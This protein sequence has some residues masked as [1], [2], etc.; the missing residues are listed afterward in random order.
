LNAE[1]VSGI[2]D[3]RSDLTTTAAAAKYSRSDGSTVVCLMYVFILDIA[4]ALVWMFWIATDNWQPAF[5]NVSSF[6][7]RDLSSKMKL[8]HRSK[9]MIV[10]QLHRWKGLATLNHGSYKGNGRKPV[11]T[12]A[13]RMPSE[14]RKR[15]AA[16]FKWRRG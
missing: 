14:E 1:G 7:E 6:A 9:R 5:P 2:F 10:A 15:I 8:Q 13:R 16:E 4:P 11:R 12:T 3:S